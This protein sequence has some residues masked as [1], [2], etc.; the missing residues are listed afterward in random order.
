MSELEQLAVVLVRLLGLTLGTLALVQAVAN[1]VDGYSSW[2]QG[3]RGHFVRV[4]LLRPCIL[5]AAAAAVWG[6]APC[7]GRALAA[8]LVG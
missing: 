8:G 6:M 2:A 7:L 1:A 3:H 4:Q 5:A